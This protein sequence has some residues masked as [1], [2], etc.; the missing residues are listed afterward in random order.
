M[1]SP[2]VSHMFSSLISGHH[3]YKEAKRYSFRAVASMKQMRQMLPPDLI[4]G[5]AIRASGFASTA[6][7]CVTA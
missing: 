7:V 1:V 6:R 4:V 3:V 2:R 5:D